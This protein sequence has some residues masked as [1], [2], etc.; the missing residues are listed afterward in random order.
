AVGGVV[1]VLLLAIQLPR[2]FGGS[3]SSAAL[4]AETSATPALA[5]DPTSA[6]PTA[7]EEVVA[8]ERA[9]S[10]KLRSF[11]LF[12]GKDP[13]IQKVTLVGVTSGSATS[14]SA[15]S[16]SAT[17]ERAASGEATGGGGRN[18]GTATTVE[19]GSS[20]PPAKASFTQAAQAT[21]IR[22]NGVPEALELGATFPSTDPVLVLVAENP[23]KREVRIGVVGGRYASGARTVTLRMG[24][25]LVLENTAT[26]AT[27]RLVLVSVGD[28][29]SARAESA[30]ERSGAAG[31]D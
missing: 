23:A 20:E 29:S 14:G 24:K 21:V 6:A 8:R 11:S 25:P 28:G 13:F 22:V 31:G 27:Y 15:T 19:S 5:S 2:I 12:A 1:L 7:G 26:G 16:G 30:R 9:T 10:T 18:A 17:S 3:S 4:P